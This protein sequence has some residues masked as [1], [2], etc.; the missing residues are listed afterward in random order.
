MSSQPSNTDPG[1][2]PPTAIRRIVTGHDPKGTSIV[3]EDKPIEPRPFPG[4]P[5]FFTDLYW[6]DSFPSDNATGP[7]LEFKDLVKDHPT[8][9]VSPEGSSFRVA[10]MPPGLSSVSDKLI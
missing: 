9:L 3:L 8:D 6:T 5:G 7:N 4:A 2:N 1:T 10:W